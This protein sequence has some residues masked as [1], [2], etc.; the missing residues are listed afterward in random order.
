MTSRQFLRKTAKTA[1]QQA[2]TV[3]SLEHAWCRQECQHAATVGKHAAP[4]LPAQLG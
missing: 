2:C 1:A 3:A 4:E